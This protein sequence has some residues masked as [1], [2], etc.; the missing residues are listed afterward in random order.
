M[1]KTEGIMTKELYMYSPDSFDIKRDK[2]FNISEIKIGQD[3]IPKEKWGNYKICKATNINDKVAG[4][5][6]EFRP[7]LKSLALIGDLTNYALQHQNRQLKNS[8]KKNGIVSY[9]GTMTA[10]KKEEMMKTIKAMG[11]G[12]DTGGVAFL[13]ADTIEFRPTHD[14]TQELD[15]LES[16]KYVEEVISYCLGVPAPLISSRSSTYNNQKEAKKKVYVDTIIPLASDYCED[17]TAFFQADLQ[18]GL[19]IWY[20]VSSIEELKEDVLTEA[21]NIREALKNIAT[22]NEVRKA[23]WDK[24]GIELKPLKSDIGD[25]VLVS[26]S[27]LFLDDL[28]LDLSPTPVEDTKDTTKE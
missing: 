18:D 7:I 9:K 17:L 22:V 2:A 19:S 11:T 26:S 24:T 3:V 10:D 5:S 25:K 12:E 4:K 8:G 13:P 6:Q 28:N 16:L 21:K 23:I 14:T 20:D 27:D 15:W 1:Y